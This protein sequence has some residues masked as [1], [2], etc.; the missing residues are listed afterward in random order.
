[1]GEYGL[2][3]RKVLWTV[4]RGG[5]IRTADSGLAVSAAFIDFVLVSACACPDER[6]MLLKAVLLR[7]NGCTL[8]DKSCFVGVMVAVAHGTKA[9]THHHIDLS[10]FFII[11]QLRKLTSRSLF[12]PYVSTV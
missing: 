12:A 4:E 11:K 1:M 9:K 8:F 10:V 6:R 3:H 5:A 7:G 2:P